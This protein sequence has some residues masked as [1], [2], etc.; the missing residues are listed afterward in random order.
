MPNFYIEIITPERKFF[1]GNISSLIVKTTDG[2]MGILKG[3]TPM[4]VAIQTG[5]IKIKQDGEW[6][7]AILTEGFVEI[8]NDKTLIFVDAAEWPHEIDENRA[9]YAK[10]RAE[11]RLKKHPNDLE[12]IR[13]NA[14]YIRANERLKLIKK[15]P[16]L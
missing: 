6:I 4:V 1:S 9:T 10:M 2:E 14:A 12:Y 3:H 7:E 15:H 16:K 5:I 13:S 8:T 11:N